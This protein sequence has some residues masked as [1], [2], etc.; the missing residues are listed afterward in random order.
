MSRMGSSILLHLADLGTDSVNICA[1]MSVCLCN[2][3]Y[4]FVFTRVADLKQELIICAIRMHRTFQV[5]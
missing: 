4:L 1:R 2:R 3:V 5:I